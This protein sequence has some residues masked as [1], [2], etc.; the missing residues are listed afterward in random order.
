M[1]NI[2]PALML[3]LNEAVKAGN[4]RVIKA[5]FVAG[6]DFQNQNYNLVIDADWYSREQT[7]QVNGRSIDFD[8]S[9]A[10]QAGGMKSVQSVFIDNSVGTGTCTLEALSTG[11]RISC[12]AGHMGWFPVITG[13]ENGKFR[14]GFSDKYNHAGIETPSWYPA[15][16]IAGGSFPL[17][18]A[19]TPNIFFTDLAV[20]PCVWSGRSDSGVWS[21]RSLTFAST[22]NTIISSPAGTPRMGVGFK[23][24]SINFGVV[25]IGYLNEQNSTIYYLWFLN[26]GEE[27]IITGRECP[28]QDLYAQTP[29]VG[30]VLEAYELL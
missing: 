5:A 15:A 10:M 20:P 8:I 16:Q 24:D 26:P 1:P 25:N 28:M 12:P 13:R 3:P 14:V 29:G 4:H 23:A 11:H 22:A 17:P 9:Q 30:N 19:Y 7:I 2:S 27:L 21:H 18:A 6:T